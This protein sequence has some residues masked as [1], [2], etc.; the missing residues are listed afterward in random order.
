MEIICLRF[1]FLKQ[2]FTVWPGLILSTAG[3]WGCI[4]SAAASL[5]NGIVLLDF[6]NMV[7]NNGF[8]PFVITCY[9]SVAQ[10]SPDLV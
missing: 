9:H 8:F 5:N 10:P 1:L 3:L 6:V 2:K 4:A 7:R